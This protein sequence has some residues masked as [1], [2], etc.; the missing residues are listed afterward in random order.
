MWYLL[1]KFPVLRSFRRWRVP[2]TQRG[3]PQQ[4]IMKMK[5][6]EAKKAV[7]EGDEQAKQ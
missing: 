4:H 6:K 1:H 7:E 5:Q 3:K 2:F